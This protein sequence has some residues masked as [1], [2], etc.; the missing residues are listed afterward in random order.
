MNC[1]LRLHEAVES[2]AASLFEREF[3]GT[4]RFTVRRRI[5]SGGFG[6]VYELHDRSRDAILARL[7]P[8]LVVSITSAEFLETANSETLGFSFVPRALSAIAGK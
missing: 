7:P 8:R 6:T 1:L 3:A 5:G 4:E 2:A